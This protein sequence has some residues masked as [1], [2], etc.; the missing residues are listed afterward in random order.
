LK[1]IVADIAPIPGLDLALV[2]RIWP[3][4]VVPSTIIQ[5]D[6]LWNYID[7]RVPG[8]FTHHRALQPPTLLSIEDYE[9]A[10]AVVETGQGL[11]AVLAAR[12]DSPY[13]RMPPS[14]FFQRHFRHVGRPRYVDEQLRLVGDEARAALGFLDSGGGEQSPSS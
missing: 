3:I 6:V 2:E 14:H 12:M 11:P 9:R 8:L 13:R 7:E 10:M 1:D 5:S 4:V